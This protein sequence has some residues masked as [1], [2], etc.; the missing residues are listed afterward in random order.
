MDIY[1]NCPKIRN[2]TPYQFMEAI[3]FSIA[4]STSSF[5]YTHNIIKNTTG[6][7]TMILRKR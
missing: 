2:H 1:L 7:N 5:T 4:D 3:C 6:K